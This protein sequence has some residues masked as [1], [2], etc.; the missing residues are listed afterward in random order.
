MR[1]LFYQKT[2]TLLYLIKPINPFS[3]LNTENKAQKLLELLQKKNQS[4]FLHTSWRYWIGQCPCRCSAV[5]ISK[6]P[7]RYPSVL[8]WMTIWRIQK[9]KII[10]TKMGLRTIRNLLLTDWKR[11]QGWTCC[12][13]LCCQSKTE[14]QCTL[15]QGGGA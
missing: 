11:K 2:T 15:V 4:S 13:V 14:L 5:R 7:S 10:T 1:T 6:L 3:V 9:K 8:T 12:S